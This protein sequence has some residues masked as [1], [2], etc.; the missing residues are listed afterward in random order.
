MFSIITTINTFK[1]CNMGQYA[2]S[3]IKINEGSSLYPIVMSL[4]VAGRCLIARKF[5]FVCP[6]SFNI[7]PF[8]TNFPFFGF[9]T[10][11]AG[12]S[13]YSPSR[14][15]LKIHLYSSLSLFCCLIPFCSYKA[16]YSTFRRMTIMGAFVFVKF[17]KRFDFM[18]LTALFLF[19]LLASFLQI[20]KPFAGNS[21]VGRQSH[22]GIVT[23]QRAKINNNSYLG[24]VQTTKRFIN[25]I[26]TSNYTINGGF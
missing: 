23:K 19:H 4:P 3:D 5:S 25:A 16:T 8:I 14:F 6:H 24:F 15:G 11:C 12:L 13:F 20:K 7:R 1:R 9:I 2:F 26:G 22:Q 18:T 21:S 10:F 17:C